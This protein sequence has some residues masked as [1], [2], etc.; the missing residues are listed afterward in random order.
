MEFVRL[1]I[2]PT[3][4][5]FYKAASTIEMNI[6]GDFLASDVGYRSV[7]FKEWAYNTTSQNACGNLTALEKKDSN[8]FLKDLFPEKK[9]LSILKISQ[10]QFIQLLT[11]WQEQVC[12][13]QP[14]EIVIKHDNNQFVIE[15]NFLDTDYETA[16]EQIP[17][18]TPH[19]Y[20]LWIKISFLMCCVIF[21]LS[22]FNFPYYFRLN[23]KV[24]KARNAFIKKNYG[25]AIYYFTKLSEKLPTNKYMKRYLA[26]SLFTSE[27]TNDHM[28]ALD[29]LSEVELKD[30]EWK[31]LLVYM[32]KEYINHFKTVIT[33]R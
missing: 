32:P 31:E 23:K 33:K 8:I 4:R 11:D 30:K 29:I 7:P 10:Q 9:S 3:K 14:Q 28:E 20:P 26:Q 24:Q 18:I 25:E 6:L 12:N 21:F 22:L 16:P 15:T 17:G 27:D 19:L 13:S 1:S 5:Y 2:S